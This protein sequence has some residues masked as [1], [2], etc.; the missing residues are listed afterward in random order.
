MQSP[1]LFLAR[2]HSGTSILSKILEAN[3]VFM[4]DHKSLN[5]TYD[6]LPCTYDFQRKLLPMNWVWGEGCMT[7]KQEVMAAASRCLA[8]HMVG[9]NGGPW[10]IKTCAGMFSYPMWNMVFPKAKY[11][12]L[13]RDGRDVIR[14]GN[15]YFH[16]SNPSSREKDWEYFKIITFGISNDMNKCP[17][18]MPDGPRKNDG[19]MRNR[20]WIQAKSWLEHKKM[21]N[22]IESDNIFHLK[23]EDI[24]R[25]PNKALQGMFNFLGMPYAC[26][27]YVCK[28]FKGVP[29][30]WRASSVGIDKRAHKLMG[31]ES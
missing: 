23:Y 10:G 18:V 4:G 20:F 16:M 29:G 22:R 26:A 9:Y 6:S 12:Y 27:D 31:Y 1:I 7:G 2:G 13:T 3:G 15:G 24:C 28:N 8:R 17:F 25:K 5:P 14:S 21:F 19:V 11:I 30:K